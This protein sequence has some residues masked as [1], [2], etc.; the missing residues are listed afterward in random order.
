MD[1][2][3]LLEEYAS[4]GSEDA[5]RAL[6]DRYA[7]MV[8]HAALRQVASP[9]AAQEVTQTVFIALAQKAGRIPRQTVLYG[10]IFRATRYAVLHLVREETCRRRYEK[11]AVTM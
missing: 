11:E 8:Y 5:F 2:W 10:W 3:Q 9:Q 1:D 6:V 4:R 7:G